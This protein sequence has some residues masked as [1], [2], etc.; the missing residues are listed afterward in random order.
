MR[1]VHKVAV[2]DYRGLHAAE[3]NVALTLEGGSECLHDDARDLARGAY[4]YRV[5][6]AVQRHVADCRVKK[7]DRILV[8][9]HRRGEWPV[10]IVQDTAVPGLAT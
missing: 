8:N 10:L 5:G 3:D 1:T 9:D 6:A 2:A 7:G 4:L